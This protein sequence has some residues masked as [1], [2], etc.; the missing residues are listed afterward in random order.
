MIESL[1][2]EN[3]IGE[4]ELNFPTTFKTLLKTLI[5]VEN[6]SS[7]KSFKVSVR[8]TKELEFNVMQKPGVITKTWGGPN[9]VP[10]LLMHGCLHELTNSKGALNYATICTCTKHLAL[11]MVKGDVQN[12]NTKKHEH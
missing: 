4:F 5:I 7:R 12:R 6:I 9:I 3:G 11:E 2:Q 10:R 8:G 1:I